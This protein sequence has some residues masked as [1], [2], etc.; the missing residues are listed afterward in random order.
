MAEVALCVRLEAKPGQEEAL[1]KF[2]KDALAKA[3]EE[4][5]TPIWFA[6]RFGAGSF[7]IFDAFATNEARQAHLNGKIPTALLARANELLASA[8][9]IELV[10]VLAVK[11]P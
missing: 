11:L 3:M 1:E 4:P 2:L 9:K 8:P 5:D 7:G 10:D 6:L